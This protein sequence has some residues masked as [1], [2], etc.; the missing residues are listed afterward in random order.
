M[1]STKYKP[2]PSEETVKFVAL[3]GVEEIGRNCSFFEYKNQIVIIDVGIQFPEENTPGVDY[4][5]PNVS[6]LEQKKANIQGIILTHGHYDHI[7]AIH[8]LIEKL[9]NPII[10]ASPF[11]RAIV[12]KRHEEFPN[13][14]KLRF[15]NVETGKRIKISE[16]FTVEFL[17]VEHTIPESLGFLLETPA[18][19]MVSFGDFRL[20][21]DKHGKVRNLE[22]F[23]RLRDRDIHTAFMD[24]TS[25]DIAGKGASEETVEA[26]LEALI[27]GAKGRVIV[28]LFASLVDRILEI[29]NIA[30]RLGR[31]VTVN[32]RSMK[33]N[34]EIA[35]Q[36]GYMK[37]KKDLIFPLEEI[38]KHRD[39]KVLLLTT[40]TQGEAN[41]GLMRI[42]NGEHRVV[43]LKPTDTV[44][45]SSSVIPGN[46]RSVQTLTD[47]I[48][49]QVDQIYNSA[50]L[51]IHAGGHIHAEDAKIV[52]EH[53]KPRFIVPI[54][55]YYFK[56]KTYQKV[57]EM[58]GLKKEQ[59][60][61]LDNGQVLSLSKDSAKI[62]DRTVPS[63]YIMVDGLGVGD[64]E[65][66]VLRDRLALAQEGMAV[67]VLTID[68]RQGKLLKS[69]DIISRGFIYLKE[70]QNILE[71]MR[72]KV[73]SLMARIPSH[74]P[75]DSDYVKGLVRDQMGQF[76]YQKTHRRPM[77]LPVIIEI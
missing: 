14:P 3:G 66:I 44:I 5:I 75:L 19:N 59:V 23:D 20:D 65:E 27:K 36:L 33:T 9:G 54:H 48:A 18:G 50:L 64:V 31:K 72:K 67:I 24:S 77:I 32:G 68:R 62:L 13:V 58:A 43:A 39:D 34:L 41:A 69:P 17:E 42:V 45:F 63:F 15:I 55:G 60:I 47:N 56:R 40:G 53:V 7:A 35:R 2:E 25:A 74:Q 30:D 10:Y 16:D 38:N 12:E 8:Y 1:V 70:N 22:V 51:D 21:F 11:T 26:N 76:I 4:I 29:I 28:A 46:E 73:R 52:L 57:A 37:D 49:R 6:Y 71:E 61:L